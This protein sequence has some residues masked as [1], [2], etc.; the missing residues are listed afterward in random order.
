MASGGGGCERL[1]GSSA[2]PTLRSDGGESVR[3]Q[4]GG[5]ARV[6]CWIFI[7]FRQKIFSYVVGLE[8]RMRKSPFFLC[9]YASRMGKLRFSQTFSRMWVG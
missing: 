8:D 4:R 9:G 5:T 2:T 6:F 3:P 7:F 1:A